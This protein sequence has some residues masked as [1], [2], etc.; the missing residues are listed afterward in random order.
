MQEYSARCRRV[1]TSARDHQADAE[2][3]EHA[4]VVID[5]AFTETV[6]VLQMQVAAQVAERRL[7]QRVGRIQL[8]AIRVRNACPCE[9]SRRTAIRPFRRS[10]PAS[11]HTCGT[12]EYLG[13]PAFRGSC[14]SL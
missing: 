6:E 12:R 8:E 11:P 13:Y 4:P 7:L 10:L 2:L 3:Q 5:Q 9:A 14:I 1:S